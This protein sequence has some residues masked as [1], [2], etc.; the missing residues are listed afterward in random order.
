MPKSTQELIECMERLRHARTDSGTLAV[1]APQ[2]AA[3][4]GGP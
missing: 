4:A 2:A 1:A 3:L